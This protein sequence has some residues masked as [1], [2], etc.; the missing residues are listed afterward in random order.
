MVQPSLEAHLR[1]Q[2][3]DAEIARLKEKDAGDGKAEPEKPLLR[4]IQTLTVEPAGGGGGVGG[5]GGGA[6]GASSASAGGLVAP[7][8]APR[9]DSRATP[10]AV[11]AVQT[12]QKPTLVDSTPS[13][14]AVKTRNPKLANMMAMIKTEDPKGGQLFAGQVNT[15]DVRRETL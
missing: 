6:G 12:A 8:P 2:Q 13:I 4:K 10:V 14:D 11:P 5:V 15:P 3:I 7:V 9:R 1:Q